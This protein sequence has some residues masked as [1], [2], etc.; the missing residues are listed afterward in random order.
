[1]LAMA[2]RR[3][4]AWRPP[5]LQTVASTG[6]GVDELLAEVD[7]HAAWLRESGELARRRTLRARRE[8]EAVALAT[9]QARWGRDGAGAD[10]DALAARVAAGEVDPYAAADELLAE[11]RPSD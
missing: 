4:G 3:D 8:V 2:E 6:R 11:G 7:R 10:L 9:L 1:M 5:V